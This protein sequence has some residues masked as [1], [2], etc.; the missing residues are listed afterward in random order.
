L[1]VGDVNGVVESEYGFHV[2]RLDGR[3]AIPF[4][5]ARPGL[6]AEVAAELSTPEASGGGSAALWSLGRDDLLTEAERRGL[7]I[8]AADEALAL[9][10]WEFRVSG[11]T[12]AFGFEA[13]IP[14]G[15][16]RERALL[17]LGSTDQN[18]RI[19]R[20]E[21]IEFREV[22]LAAYPVVDAGP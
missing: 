18:A 21:V 19:A 16:I 8:D 7:T 3:E 1:E 4:R 5:E 10:E 9:R 6:V 14:P 22:L 20:S 11:W 12:G 2:I 15:E 17:A 13:G